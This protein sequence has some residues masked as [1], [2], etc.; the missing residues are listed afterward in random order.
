MRKMSSVSI[1]LMDGDT[2]FLGADYLERP[3][4]LHPVSAV[5]GDRSE[6]DAHEIIRATLG[7]PSSLDALPALE[8]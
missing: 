2:A 8:F 5:C 6:M 1:S 4:V 3:I 7:L